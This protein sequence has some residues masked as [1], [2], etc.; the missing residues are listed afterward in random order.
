[1][2]KADLDSI[3]SVMLDSH[4]GISDLLFCVGKPFQVESFGVLKAVEMHHPDV[5]SL[6]SWQVEQIALLIIGED[7]R[8]LMDFLQSG[9]CD[10]AYSLQEKARFRVNIFR[11]R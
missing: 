6:T 5:T 4:P 10:C 11:Q 7:R 2:N 9:S 8:L 3:I 1:M